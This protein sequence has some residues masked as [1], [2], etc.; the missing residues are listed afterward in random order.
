MTQD[1]GT[2]PWHE[3][4]V[5]LTQRFSD[6]E[7][8]PRVVRQS[9]DDAECE[10]FFAHHRRA[11]DRRYIVRLP[12]KRSGTEL[13]GESLPSVRASLRSSQRRLQRESEMA[14]EY[15]LFVDEYLRCGQMRPLTDAELCASP[16][17]V[18]YISYHGIWQAG[19]QRRRL[20]IVFNAS[21]PT[22][23][24]YSLNDALHA[25]PKLQTCLPSVL[26][27]WRR[28]RIAFCADI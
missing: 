20:R 5:A 11:A 28:H 27:R 26:L 14:A 1:A 6:L 19:D 12:L 7:D 22:S 3:Q 23:T 24:G 8:V 13:L 18:H 2:P 4:L 9:P 21:R 10:T 16:G 17:P 25:G 15:V